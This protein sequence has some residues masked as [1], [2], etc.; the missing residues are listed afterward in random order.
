LCFPA[1][2]RQVI[3][4]ASPSDGSPC[5]IKAA[6]I[7]ALNHLLD[8]EPWA[9]ER[10]IPFA[11]K[12]VLFMLPPFAE[13]ALSILDSGLVADGRD[14]PAF[15]LT[16]RLSPGLVPRLLIRD[17]AATRSVDVTG[18]TGLARTVEFLFEHLRWDAEDD[19]ARVVGDAPAHR[20]GEAAHAAV[21]WQ[22][23]ASER[24]ARNVVEYLTEENAVVTSGA[25]VREFTAEVDELRDAV[26]RLEKRIARLAAREKLSPEELRREPS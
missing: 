2:E 25:D 8:R 15:D 23:E 21:A 1:G 19:L 4:V 20:I 14:S 13:L 5:V 12:R 17:P 26:E 18:D 16:V 24:L 22:R 10:L 9:R 11:G 6:P 7:A 3:F